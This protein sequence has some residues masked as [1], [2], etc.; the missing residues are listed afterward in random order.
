MRPAGGSETRHYFN[1]FALL[2]PAR[3]AGAPTTPTG[4]LSPVAVGTYSSNDMTER[5]KNELKRLLAAMP[6]C[7]LTVAKRLI[8][9]ELDQRKGKT[10]FRPEQWNPHLSTR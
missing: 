10:K 5:D 6:M 1:E 9:D 3:L 2:T 8:S 7:D 4:G